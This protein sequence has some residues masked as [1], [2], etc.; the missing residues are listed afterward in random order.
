MY[1]VLFYT[2]DDTGSNVSSCNVEQRCPQ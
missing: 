1:E 2:T